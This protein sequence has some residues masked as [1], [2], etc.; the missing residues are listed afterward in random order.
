[1]R[2]ALVQLKSVSRT[3]ILPV[4][5]TVL[6]I[7]A[8]ILYIWQVNVTATVGFEMRDLEYTIEEYAHEQ[9]RLDIRVAQL[10]SIES[11]ASRMNML[12]LREV[13]RVEYLVPG[14]SNVAI[15]K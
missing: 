7:C 9:Q 3:N 14:G 8:S 13:K 15:N 6:T 1:M 4:H 11:V 5:L 10:R 2:K 12:G